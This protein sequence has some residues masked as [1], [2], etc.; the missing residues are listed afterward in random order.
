MTLPDVQLNYG[1]S[2]RSK[3]DETIQRL[4]IY[5]QVASLW[6]RKKSWL[7]IYFKSGLHWEARHA[8]LK[9]GTN[10]PA[11]WLTVV[12]VKYW[13]PGTARRNKTSTDSDPICASQVTDRRI[14][15]ERQEFWN[16]HSVRCSWIVQ[17]GSVAFGRSM[18]FSGKE[19]SSVSSSPD[20]GPF[21]EDEIQQ[22]TVK[23]LPSWKCSVF[24]SSCS[25]WDGKRP[26]G[27]GLHCSAGES[28]L[29]FPLWTRI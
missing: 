23:P 3:R 5:W 25:N 24:T 27:G 28:N 10:P 19:H 1:N 29:L 21:T 20:C 13:A 12:A 16:W 15:W 26:L 7:V 4:I 2:N 6:D 22:S 8:E 9:A 17:A 11:Q 18:A 14:H